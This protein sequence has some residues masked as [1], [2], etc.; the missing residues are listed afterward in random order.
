MHNNIT[1]IYSCTM[2]FYLLICHWIFSSDISFLLH[3]STW[4][5]DVYSPIFFLKLRQHVFLIIYSCKSYIFWDVYY[6]YK[7][8]IS[9]QALESSNTCMYFASLYYW[10]NKETRVITCTHY[11]TQ[12]SYRDYH[13]SK[14]R[15]YVIALRQESQFM[16]RIQGFIASK[17][18]RNMVI[19]TWF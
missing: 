17:L 13:G 6:C 3:N 16:Y 12:L 8:H 19:S 4:Q 14:W 11:Q 9:C 7:S 15:T 1:Y 5:F 2:L 18:K 10:T